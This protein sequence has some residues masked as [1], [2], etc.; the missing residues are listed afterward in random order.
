MSFV[1]CKTPRALPVSG[2]APLKEGPVRVL[3]FGDLHFKPR[4]ARN[5]AAFAER[6]LAFAE[7]CNKAGEGCSIDAAVC[8]GDVLDGHRTVDFPAQNR[9]FRFFEALAQT[10]PLFV[11]VG[12]HDRASNTEHLTD[13]SALL[14]FK[15]IPGV[16]LVDRVSAYAI[17]AL[18]FLFV[19]YVHKGRFEEAVGPIR[20]GAVAAVFAHQEF[21]GAV[22]LGARR[23]EDGDDWAGGHPL[24]ISG[25]FHDQQ[26]LGGNVLYVGAAFQQNAKE[27]PHKGFSLFDFAPGGGCVWWFAEGVVEPLLEVRIRAED[28]NGYVPPARGKVRL[29]VE[30]G[31]EAQLCALEKSE[32]VRRLRARG[33]DV[34]LSKPAHAPARAALCA[35]RERSLGRLLDQ[36]LAGKTSLAALWK[37]VKEATT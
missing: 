5:D 23:S 26:A 32:S 4:T 14:T 35:S 3:V 31:D 9:A 27:D 12:N 10:A 20:P 24:V 19:P 1:G 18:R 36:S 28:L 37:E 30:C 33:V 8:L 29:L 34:R 21:R 6:T 11:L 2:A 25:H 7:T 16:V 13:E 17:G 22:S 15:H